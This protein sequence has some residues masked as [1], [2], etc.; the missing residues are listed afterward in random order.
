MTDGTPSP[1]ALRLRLRA[2]LTGPGVA[3]A[4]GCYDSISARL[5]EDAGFAVAYATGHG[6][7]RSIGFPDV[8]LVTLSEV[9]DRLR[10]IC[11]SIAIP[12]IADADTGYGNAINAARAVQEFEAAGVA[13]LHIEDQVSPKRC[14]HLRDAGLKKEVVPLAEQVGKLRAASEARI[15]PNTVLIARIDARPAGEPMERVLERGRAYLQAGAD[16]LMP[17]DLR[18]R[19]EH[20]AFGQVFSGR[21][22][23]IPPGSSGKSW[24][25]GARGDA[26]ADA[27]AQ[28]DAPALGA[29]GYRVALAPGSVA[30]AAI[31]AMRDVL[32]TMAAEQSDGS[33]VRRTPDAE[34][35]WRW[36]YLSRVDAIRIAEERYLQVEAGT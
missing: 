13:G 34:A 12:L 28:L 10:T 1:G 35:V 2:L 15:D 11:R 7:A 33:F 17:V 5:V 14:G 16:L 9:I 36:Y 4:P 3:L 8:G 25:R 31:A 30:M 24:R 26:D 18:S 20:A 32:A 29:L 23:I 27:L 19:E 21:A 6:M 22:V